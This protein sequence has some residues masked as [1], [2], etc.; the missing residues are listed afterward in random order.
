MLFLNDAD[1]PAVWQLGKAGLSGG[2]WRSRVKVKRC[3]EPNQLPLK[4]GWIRA[5]SQPCHCTCRLMEGVLEAGSFWGA[6]R[7]QGGR[8]QGAV[9]S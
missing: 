1:N 3:F 7:K 6:L 8:P 5:T 2:C 4:R 9:Q